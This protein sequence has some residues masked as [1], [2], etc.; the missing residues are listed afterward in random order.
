MLLLGYFLL[1]PLVA[2]LAMIFN[3]GEGHLSP[4]KY[5]YSTLIYLV[6][7]PGIFAVT[8]SIYFFLFERRSILDTN[9]YTQI[10]PILSM[11]L[12][13]ILIKKQ[14][15][16]DLVPGFGKLSGLITI[17][18]V[19]MVLMWIIDKTRIYSITFMPFYVVVL[20]LVVGFVLIRAG[21]KRMTS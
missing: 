2:V 10:L 17:I 4:W 20:I 14:V 13:I 15:N 12:T 21:F 8:L 11:I 16:L 7:V 6:C 3:N 1:I 19:V 9:I 18:S 5:L